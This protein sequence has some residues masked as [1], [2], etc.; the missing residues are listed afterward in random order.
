M[1]ANTHS[2]YRTLKGWTKCADAART[3]LLDC[4]GLPD[5]ESGSYI[6]KMEGDADWESRQ[7]APAKGAIEWL[8][9]N[10]K[11]TPL[12]YWQKD[13]QGVILI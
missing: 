10:K 2:H 11:G 7:H 8:Y 3:R 1:D 12:Y 5:D 6:V 13:R 4:P 9:L